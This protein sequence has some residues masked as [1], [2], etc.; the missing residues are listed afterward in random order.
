MANALHTCLC[1]GDLQKSRGFYEA[2]GFSFERTVPVVRDGGRERVAGEGEDPN[3]TIDWFG[4]GEQQMTLELRSEHD[5]HQGEPEP[6]VGLFVADLHAT[7]TRL[8]EQG[9]E[10]ETPPYEPRKGVFIAFVRDPDRNL[11]E[12]I[13]PP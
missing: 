12:L 13:G 3:T 6:H 8:A 11:I 7:V 1:V 9:F 10:I 2:L 5:G 4:F